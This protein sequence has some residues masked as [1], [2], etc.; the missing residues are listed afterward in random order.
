MQSKIITL[1]AY[2]GMQS[3]AHLPEAEALFAHWQSATVPGAVLRKNCAKIRAF[4]LAQLLKGSLSA[5]LR[6]DLPFPPN[7]ALAG[8]YDPLRQRQAATPALPDA[9]RL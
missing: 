9:A 7:I 2:W 5:L 6:R 3:V 8:C 4:P 1:K